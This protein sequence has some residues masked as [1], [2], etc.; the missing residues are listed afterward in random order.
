VVCSL[1]HVSVFPALLAHDYVA[2]I[3]ASA[4]MWRNIT[5]QILASMARAG[6]RK[7]CLMWKT[8]RSG[9]TIDVGRN[10]NPC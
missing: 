10:Q 5:A 7:E 8:N 2:K 9:N 4:E 3:R 6:I 1:L